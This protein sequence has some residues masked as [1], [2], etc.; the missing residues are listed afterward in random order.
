[1][2]RAHRFL[3]QDVTRAR[4]IDPALFHDNW[5]DASLQTVPGGVCLCDF[6]RDGILDMLVT[7]VVMP[8]MGGRE[9]AGRL[10][11]LRPRLRVLY[12]SGYT[13]DAVVRHGILEAEVEFLQKPFSSD[14]LARTVRDMLDAKNGAARASS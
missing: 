11:A 6:D 10:V 3:F 5:R 9:L 2:G 4:G 13:D 14:V 7:D 12:L 1:M 8:R